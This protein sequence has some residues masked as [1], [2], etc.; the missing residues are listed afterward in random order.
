[1]TRRQLLASAAALAVV[2]MLPALPHGAAAATP[3]RPFA[4]ST[5]EIIEASE[6]SKM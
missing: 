5:P 2:A 6:I 1:M 4:F 3:K